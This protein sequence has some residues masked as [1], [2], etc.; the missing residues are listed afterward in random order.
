MRIVGKDIPVEWRDHYEHALDRLPTLWP[1]HFRD[2]FTHRKNITLI[3]GDHYLNQFLCP[4][5]ETAPLAVMLDIHSMWTNLGADELWFMLISFFTP[6]QRCADGLEH[7]LLRHY[8]EGLKGGGVR[9]YSWEELMRDSRV[10]A[11]WRIFHPVWDGAHGTDRAYWEPKMRCAIGAYE[12]LQCAELL[13][14]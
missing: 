2:R 11:I 14:E 4:R 8:Q 13:D 10:K 7:R 6:E 12:D 9:D 5:D 1:R 3:S